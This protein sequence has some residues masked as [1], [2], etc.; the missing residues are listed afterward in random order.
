MGSTNCNDYTMVGDAINIA[1]RLQDEAGPGE[2]LLTQNAYDLVRAGFPS[3]ERREYRLK[4][5]DEPVV[6]YAI[7]RGGR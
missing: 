6:A 3:A 5:I 2:I 7:K 4:G 1:S